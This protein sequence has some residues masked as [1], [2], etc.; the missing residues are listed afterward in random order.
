MASTPVVVI[1]G[2]SS[3]IG[4]ATAHAFARQGACLVLIARDLEAL[5]SVSRECGDMGAA[6]TIPISADTSDAAALDRAASTAVDG[7]GGVDIWV[8]AAAV[9]MFGRFEDVPAHEFDRLIAV[10]VHGYANGARAALRI[11]RGR[12]NRG[13]LIFVGSMLGVV[14][15]PYVSAYVASKFAIRG[16][17]A[18]LRQELADSPDIHICTIL[19]AAVVT[20]IYQKA[21]NRIGRPARSIFPVYAPERLAEATVM[22]ARRPK[23]EL[24]FSG[25]SKVLMLGSRLAPGLVERLVA[26]AAW[27]LQFEENRAE[28]RPG[29]L[30]A[31]EP[32]TTI[33][34]GWRAYW[35]RRLPWSRPSDPA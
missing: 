20:P 3:G 32:P 4:R 27:K 33:S 18:A 1:T 29:N 6:G 10:N 22:L 7:F 15:E 13:V 11:F 2:A 9:L 24:V 17:A 5:Q 26:R 14:S 30:F 16:L 19:P 25:F 23:P 8:H 12:G 35:R 34:G 31:S 28:P 21:A